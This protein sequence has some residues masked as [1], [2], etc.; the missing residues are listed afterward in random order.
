MTVDGARPWDGNVPDIGRGSVA[1]IL[2]EPPSAA[3]EKFFGE[4]LP[5]VL[6]FAELLAAEG[7]RRGLIGPREVPRLWSRHIV[8]SAAVSTFMGEARTVADVGSGAGLPGMVLALMRPDVEVTLV[9]PMERRVDWL[10]YAS[11]ALGAANVEIVRARAEDLHGTRGFDVV[12]AR[13]VAPLDRLVEWTVPLVKPGGR[14]LALKGRRAAEE[15]RAAHA[16]LR[17]FEVRNIAIETVAP[18]ESAEPTTIVVID[19]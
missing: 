14:L 13:A 4:S 16:S 2:M 6:S 12:T 7:E 11:G 8:N 17:N 18:F 15:V 19:H 5:Q 3:S 9:E 1:P 10:Q